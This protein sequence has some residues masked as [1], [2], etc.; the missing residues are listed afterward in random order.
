MKNLIY[1]KARAKFFIIKIKL[2]SIK[3]LKNWWKDDILYYTISPLCSMN[4]LQFNL[5]KLLIWIIFT[6]IGF[7][8][9]KPTEV[10]FLSCFSFYFLLSVAFFELPSPQEDLIYCKLVSAP[11][12]RMLIPML[13]TEK[14]HWIILPPKAG[15]GSAWTQHAKRDLNDL[16]CIESLKSAVVVNV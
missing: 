5:L 16:Q 7:N 1:F 12:N 6:L 11:H 8:G 4:S 10:L 9:A 15:C 2:D 13:T 14:I 3:L